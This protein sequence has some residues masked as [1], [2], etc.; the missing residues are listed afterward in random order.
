MLGGHSHDSADQ[1]DE[2][3]VPLLAAFWLARRPANDRYTDG[4]GRAED[5]GGLF[6][7]AMI[8]LSS[9]LAAYEAINRLVHPQPVTNLWVVATAALVGFGGNELVARY[10][11]QVGRRIG[12]AALV[13]DG[14]HA[15]ADGFTSL[16]VLVGAGG[17]DVRRPGPRGRPPCRGAPGDLCAATQRR[18]RPREPARRSLG[19]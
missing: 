19:A 6:V 5:V 12:S 9:A 14:L 16:A 10:R 13:A 4:F 18:D 3:A 8:A 2:T 17:G 1:V 11:I 7:V 15:R